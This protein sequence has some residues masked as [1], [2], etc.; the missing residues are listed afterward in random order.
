MVEFFKASRAANSFPDLGRVVQGALGRTGFML[1][2]EFDFGAVLRRESGSQAPNSMRL[3]VGNPLIMKEMVKHDPL[4]DLTLQSQS[5]LMN[6]PMACIS[7]MTEWRAAAVLQ[8]GSGNKRTHEKTSQSIKR[9]RILSS[10]H[11]PQ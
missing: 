7:P 11:S 10:S 3:L 2:A 8:H 5:S 6:V 4:P 9:G 1:F